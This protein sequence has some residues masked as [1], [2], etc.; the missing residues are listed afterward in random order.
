MINVS[1]P[2][3]SITE[4]KMLDEVLESGWIG[5]GQKVFTF[6]EECKKELQAKH[7]IALSSCTK[8]I[9]IALIVAGCMPGD[10]VILPS[11]T[12]ASVIQ[13]IIKLGLVPVFATIEKEDLNISVNGIERLITPKTRVIL[14]LHFRGHSCRIDDVLA[15]A[16]RHNL[17]VIE[18]AAHAFGSYYKGS[19][20]GSSSHMACFSFG[21]LK[22]ICCIEGGGIATN[23]DEI[24]E[25][26]L[27]YRNMGMARSTWHR[28]NNSSGQDKPWHYEVVARGDKCTQ[29]DVGAAVGLMQLR[30]IE[31]IRQKK[32]K[33]IE[34]YLAELP[35]EKGLEIPATD[36][37]NDFAYI[38]TVLAGASWREPLMAYL[39]EK[40][41]STAVHYYPN[42]LQPFFAKYNRG[43]LPVTEDAGKRIITLPSYTDL[44]ESEQAYIIEE[45]KKFM[46]QV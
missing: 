13:V 43:P 42:H 35:E 28:Y 38:F 36:P 22:N 19:P 10:E 4:R 3:I 45:I 7:F 33:I 46:K 32:R 17:M 29:N 25:K 44:A 27:T 2:S 8:S 16:E 14:P 37:Q 30:R 39:W 26:I 18:D 34:R 15:I 20:V 23:S 6:E 9:E 31:E 40:G 24:A 1:K 11:L 41:I 21:P 12:Y 5:Q